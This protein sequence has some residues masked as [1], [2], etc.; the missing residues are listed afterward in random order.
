MATT[1]NTM[2]TSQII[3]DSSILELKTAKQIV[4]ENSQGFF[5]ALKDF[6]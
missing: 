3:S 1:T 2:G 4:R 6:H 5:V